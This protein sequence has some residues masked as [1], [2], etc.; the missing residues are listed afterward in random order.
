M[1]SSEV[2]HHFI[3][4]VILRIGHLPWF[5][6]APIELQWYQLGSLNIPW[7]HIA[8]LEVQWYA[9]GPLELRW[10]GFMYMVGFIIAYFI[11]RHELRRRQ[12]PIAVEEADDLLFYCIVGLLLGGRL[13][14]ILIYNLKIYLS[15]P[16]E[17]FALWH[18]G[19]SFHGGLIGIVISGWIYARRRNVSFL[20]LADIVV[21]SAPLGVMLGRI[22]NFI[23]GELYGRPSNLPW[24]MVF[25]LGGNIPRHPSQLYEAFFEGFVIFW[26]LWWLKTKFERPGELLCAYL[27]LYGVFRFVIEFFREP[28]PQIGF[29]FTWFTTGQILCLA[30]IIVGTAFMLRLSSEE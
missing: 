22:G 11:I 1:Q 2:P 13:G 4:P 5:H 28:D 3:D 9:F 7:F 15:S 26:L 8:P 29:V 20:E 30:M 14:Y 19:M 16:R 27:I 10:Y 23:N 21:L 18:G 24:A 12:G 25:P 17:I 6:I